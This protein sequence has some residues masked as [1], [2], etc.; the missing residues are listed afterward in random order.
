VQGL[1]GDSA[2]HIISDLPEGLTTRGIGDWHSH[3]DLR[4]LL[5]SHG[6]DRGPHRGAGGQAIV[7]EDR[8]L[9]LQI[10]RRPLTAELLLA[11]LELLLFPPDHL[12]DLSLAEAEGADHR[13]VED[14]HAA[15]GDRPHGELLLP[16]NAELADDEDIEREMQRA[17]DL[18]GDRDSAAWQP[19]H[20]RVGSVRI[21]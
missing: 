1:G 21:G 19:E 14:A 6:G 4:R 17:R 10:Q 12:I 2:D 7:H 11:A 8:G 5:L 3:D 16:W 20:D 18:V 9:P 15:A 13:V